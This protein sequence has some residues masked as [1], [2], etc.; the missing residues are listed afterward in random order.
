MSAARMTPGPN[1]RAGA[2]LTDFGVQV[3]LKTATIGPTD[4]GSISPYSIYT[5]L[6]MTD[7]GARGTGQQQL[8][9]VLGG[10]PRRQ[11]GNVTAIDAA[12][13]TA[14][15]DSG[16]GK[17]TSAVVQ[18]ANSLWPDKELPVRKDFLHELAT[19]YGAQLHVVD[20]KGD[21]AGALKDINGWVSKRTYGLIP[22][23]LSPKEVTS[24]SLLELVNALYL[25]ASWQ[26]E[27]DAPSSPRA[28][29]TAAG[30]QVRVPY[31][32]A[33]SR[34]PVAAGDNWQSVTI[35]YV[36]GGLA[37]TIILPAKGAFG[38]IRKQLATVLPKAVQGKADGKVTLTMP[39]FSIDTR[40]QLVA[41][42]KALGVREIFGAG[43]DLS[44]IAGKPGDIKV[45][46]VVHQSIVK[47]DQHGTE[48]AAAT[49]VG[50]EPGAAPSQLPK[51]IDVDR[52]FFFAIHDTQTGAPL[53]LGQVADP[54]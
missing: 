39:P 20:Y 18:A 27:F 23:L 16:K 19:G 36:G 8:D 22:E 10:D 42:L 41:A 21:A 34:T 2:D 37:M 32:K 4:N 26:K 1:A 49:G 30:K 45:D 53:F 51:K 54:S 9:K 52:A 38:A 50:L 12:I 17:D 40:S 15:K 48:A 7:A 29:T 25:K 5:A 35:P 24:R 11:A 33:A 3:L 14:I 6:A 43:A 31:M 46:S 44:G 28:F 47:V 13:A